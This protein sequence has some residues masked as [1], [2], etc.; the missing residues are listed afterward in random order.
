M[1]GRCVFK[2]VQPKSIVPQMHIRCAATLSGFEIQ[3]KT[4]T[5]KKVMP[6]PK[7]HYGGRHTVTLLPGAGI[8][9]ELMGY[10]KEIFKYAGVPV[11][12]EEIDIDPNADN[13][14][15]LNY[16][17]TSIRRNGVALKGNIETRSKEV[18]VLSRNVA[19]RNQLDLYVNA[20]HCVSY[21]GVNSR[22]K[23]IDVVIVRQ[24]TEGEYAM[25]EHESVGGVVESMKVITKSNSERVARYAFEY[26]RRNNRKKV[27]T[28]HK[29]NIMKLSDGLFLETSRRVA[30]DYPEI[31]LNDMII[32]NTCMQLVSNPHQFDI[33]LTTNLYGAIVSNVICGLLGGAGLLAGKNYGDHFTIFEPA[34]RNTGA[35]IAG[36]NIANPIAMLNAAVDMLRHLGHKNHAVIIQSAINKTINAG[37]QTKDLGG[38]ATSREVIDNILKCIKTAQ[39]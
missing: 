16:A 21:P 7:A 22:Q 14:D 38:T 12:F 11:D 1:A 8:G 33:M 15:D 30:K 27:T 13:N 3:H 20:L 4:P 5:I 26:A 17:I 31:I 37:I 39:S 36:K 6:I 25:L 32:D 23:N 35:S 10:V 9:P 28:I 24:N 19:L 29:A 18:G 34:T 2:Y